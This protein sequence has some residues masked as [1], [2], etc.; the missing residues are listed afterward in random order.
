MTLQLAGGLALALMAAVL[1]GTFLLPIG[2]A[3]RW[4]WEHNWAVFSLFAMLLFNW[5]IASALLPDLIPVYRFVPV[6]ELLAVMLFGTAW[7]VGAVL[8]GLGVDKLGLALG[9]PIIMGL[10]A[11]LGAVI[12]LVFLVQ[13]DASAAKVMTVITGTVIAL[14]GIVVC[15]VAGSRKQSGQSTQSAGSTAFTAGLLICVASGILSGL[16][17]VGMAYAVNIVKAAKVAGAP[18]ALA[19]NAVWALFFTLGAVVNVG[20][21]VWLMVQRRNFREFFCPDSVRNLAL[22][23]LTALMWIGSFYLYGISAAL[24]G[25]W[26]AVIGWP[27]FISV[28]IGVGSLAGLWKG[29]WK[30]APASALH[31]LKNGLMV[32]LAAV[33]TLAVANA[34]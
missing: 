30:R 25:N 20:Y 5:A 19:G 14:A 31:L 11:S 33:V 1:Q 6:S 13:R 24:L 26:G 29:E 17:N 21:C 15:S 32:I 23:S 2:S 28:A 9:Y 18:E 7:G 27:V 10:N 3:R 34:L 4:R 16:P 22:G 12:P 8:F